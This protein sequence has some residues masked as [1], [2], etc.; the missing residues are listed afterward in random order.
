MNQTM[1]LLKCPAC[2]GPLEPPA[3]ESTMKCTYC[4]NSV[5]IPESLRL[6][7]EN[8]GSQPVSIFSGIDMNAMMGY[9][10]HWGEVVQMAQGGNKSEAVKKYMALTGG[11]E[12]SAVH[13]VNGLS[14]YQSYEYTPGNVQSVQQI[15]APVMA[16]TAESIKTAT[17]LS[18][19]MGC[20]ITAFVMLILLVTLIPIFIGVFASLIP[21][22]R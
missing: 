17:K 22:F 14:R 8:A 6:P 4:G 9:G 21:F 1:R 2:G 10:A 11:D 20:G 15:Y 16:Q 19:W 13:M 5:I 18:L 3:G 12:A 7:K